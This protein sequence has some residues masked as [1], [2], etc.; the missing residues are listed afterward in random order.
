MPYRRLDPDR[1][2]KTLERLSN[3]V[4]ERFPERG[5][6]KVCD[7]LL[8]IAR[9]DAERCAWAERPNYL[10]RFSIGLLLA[11][12]AGGLGWLIWR[13]RAT[14]MDMETFH[15]FQGVEAVVN[16][17]IL[18][19]GG[20]WLILNQEARLKRGR[21]L[22]D[23]H[24][25]RSIAH[26]ID[27]HQLTKDPTAIL[28]NSRSTKSSYAHDM[29]EF[30]LTRYFDYCAEMLSLTGKLAALYM[31]GTRDP[32]VIQAVNEI[33][34]LTSGLTRKIWQKIMILKAQGQRGPRRLQAQDPNE[35]A[36]ELHP[37]AI[38]PKGGG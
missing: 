14:S 16:L 6:V 23:L 38:E 19:A 27:M 35:T 20:V 25:L 26:V 34:D 5:L 29:T 33:E 8:A 18:V 24:E 13:Y 32:V 2:I 7:E 28:D 37:F 30:E 3:R 17:S 21:I 12:L 15:A 1:I 11:A 31:R 36:S 22:D 10:L 9:E 4:R